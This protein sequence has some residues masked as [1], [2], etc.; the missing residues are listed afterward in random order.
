MSPTQA[1]LG[2]VSGGLAT[3]EYEPAGDD[4]VLDPFVLLEELG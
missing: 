4:D 1:P 2:P 3:I